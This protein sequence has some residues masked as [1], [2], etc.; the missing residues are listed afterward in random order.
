MSEPRHDCPGA[1][2]KTV[3]LHLLA[4]APCWWRLPSKMRN[5]VSAAYHRREV[6]PLGHVR[7]INE[8]RRWYRDNPDAGPGGDAA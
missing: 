7:S 3:P 1:C 8:A 6:D 2:G 4:C 5:A